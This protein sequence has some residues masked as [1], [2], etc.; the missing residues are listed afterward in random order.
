V[1]AHDKGYG[2]GRELDGPRGLQGL[3]VAQIELAMEKVHDKEYTDAR[4]VLTELGAVVVRMIEFVQDEEQRA[5]SMQLIA[6]GRWRVEAD[7]A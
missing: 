6:E 4:E 7:K 1:E 3:A 5:A 2:L